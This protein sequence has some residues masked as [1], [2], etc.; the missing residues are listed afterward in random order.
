[1]WC[2]A[3]WLT[4][5]LIYN[6]RSEVHRC[7]LHHI[8]LGNIHS[9]V[10]SRSIAIE[11]TRLHLSSNSFILLMRFT[12]KSI[13]ICF[14]VHHIIDLYLSLENPL[15]WLFPF[16][17]FLSLY[18]SPS[19]TFSLS[20]SLSLLLSLLLSLSFSLSLTLSYSPSNVRP[21]H[22]PVLEYVLS[23]GPHRSS[24]RARSVKLET[25]RHFCYESPADLILW[26]TSSS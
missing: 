14:I 19:H 24:R 17:L 22:L 13:I 4:D 2:G 11:S 8:A 21:P 1:M 7:V 26:I 10:S 18:L 9:T 16:S 5:W 15:P 20:P 23:H 3:D 6:A 25:S 12:I